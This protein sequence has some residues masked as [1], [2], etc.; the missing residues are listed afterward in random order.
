M[1]KTSTVLSAKRKVRPCP[2]PPSRALP[3]AKRDAK[4]DAMK[5]LAARIRRPVARVQFRSRRCQG[6]SRAPPSTSRLSARK[7][8]CAFLVAMSLGGGRRPS[9][10]RSVP[11]VSMAGFPTIRH[12]F[13]VWM[14]DRLFFIPA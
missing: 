2:A 11:S 13:G 1:A 12:S 4:T 7:S 8:C 3:R 6:R 10:T 5:H 9:L 14:R